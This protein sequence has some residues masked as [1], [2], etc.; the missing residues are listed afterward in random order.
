MASIP[1]VAAELPPH[2]LWQTFHE[3][4]FCCFMLFQHPLRISY[5]CWS[6]P[7]PFP[8]LIY[9]YLLLFKST[10]WLVSLYRFPHH[11]RWLDRAYRS[12]SF[13]HCCWVQYPLVFLLAR[14]G[15]P[16]PMPSNLFGRPG[17]H[18]QPTFRIFTRIF[19]Y[20]SVSKP[21]TPGE[22]QNSW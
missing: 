20:G 15:N 7:S 14:V 17:N 1:I 3:V 9:C 12:L 22:H 8:P 10:S 5:V 6:K 19:L 21:C 18:L 16:K 2:Y 4:G 13:H 11:P